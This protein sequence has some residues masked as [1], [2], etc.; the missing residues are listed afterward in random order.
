MPELDGLTVLQQTQSEDNHVPIILMTAY[1]TS[2][3]AIRAMQLG[4]YD[5]ITKPFDLDDVL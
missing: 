5:Y 2:N 1:G 3:L 4:A